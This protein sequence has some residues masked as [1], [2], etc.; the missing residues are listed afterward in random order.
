MVSL[1]DPDGL[2]VDE[3]TRL[4]AVFA[5]RHGI[6]APVEPLRA[7]AN[8]VFR[9]SDVVIRVAPRSADVASQV[10]LARWLVSEDFPVAAPLADAETINGTRLS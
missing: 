5:L 10:A 4:P 2:T 7:G 3:A 8:H 6:K 1:L 9:A